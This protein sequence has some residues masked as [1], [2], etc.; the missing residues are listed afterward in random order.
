MSPRTQ[1][2]LELVV[3]RD[4]LIAQVRRMGGPEPIPLPAPPITHYPR[5]VLVPDMLTPQE[6]RDRA[7]IARR[8]AA[9][10]YHDSP[11]VI[12]QRRT[13]ALAEANSAWAWGKEA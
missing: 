12:A 9:A 2:L 3:A 7:E 5:P 1:R 10:E 4:R 6:I 8:R 13:D 11:E